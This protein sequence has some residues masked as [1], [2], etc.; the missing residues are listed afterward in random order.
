MVRALVLCGVIGAWLFSVKLFRENNTLRFLF[1]NPNV[2]TYAV[3][4]EH[5]RMQLHDVTN[6][7]SLETIDAIREGPD[8]GITVCLQTAVDGE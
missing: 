7:I 8:N 4:C 2:P 3:T 5:G 1:V 6:G